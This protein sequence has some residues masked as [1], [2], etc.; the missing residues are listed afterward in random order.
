MYIGIDLG[1]SSVKCVLVDPDQRVLGSASEALAVN[2]PAPTHAE[3]D[4]A[5]WWQATLQALDRLAADHPGAMSDVRGLGLS[6]QMHG[7]TLLD[8]ADQV[9]RPCI[10]WNDG[11]A[12][13]EC[14]EME[15]R[16]PD[17]RRVTGNIAMPGFTAPKLLWVRKHEPALFDRIAKVLLPKA[18]LR[19]RLSGEYAEDMSDAAGTLWLDV[20]KRDWSDAALAATGLTRQH[21]PR[22]VEGSA[23]AGRL[24]P[25]LQKRW[26][27]TAAPVIAGGAGDNAAGA[28][29]LGAI[30]AGDAF[31]S[32]GTS[33]VLWA[34]TAGFAPNPGKAVHAFCHCLPQTWHQMG[35][36]LSAASCFAWLA[37]TLGTSE[38]Q[39]LAGMPENPVRPGNVLFLPYLS[40]E[41]TPHND[42]RIRG[43]FIGLSHETDRAALVQAVMEGV[44]FALKDCLDALKGAGTHVSSADIIG[45]GARSPLWRAII[46]HVLDLPLAEITGADVSG[47]FGAARLGRLAATGEAPGDV[48]HKAPRGKTIQPDPILRD[49]Y[50]A[51][52]QR[53]RQLYPHLKEVA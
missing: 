7:A 38:G 47:A 2:R 44:A 36:I 32:L 45:G 1:T 26:N 34:T 48:C 41:R 53:Y 20:A 42:A 31:V 39:L 52:H 11:R 35:V 18:Y 5:G 51:N 46:A 49:A 3:Q 24:R 28:V 37:D 33:G 8:A 30:H 4:P 15:A 22:L 13:A 25:E 23:P 19:L 16:W 21:M 12:A 14:A 40:G 50:A 10:L 6:G 29:S 27:M 9:L 43:A 17:L